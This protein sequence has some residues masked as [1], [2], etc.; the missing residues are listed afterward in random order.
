MESLTWDA[1][2]VDHHTSAPF[3]LA[4]EVRS[5]IFRPRSPVFAPANRAVTPFGLAHRR[6]SCAHLPIIASGLIDRPI[7]VPGGMDWLAFNDL[8]SSAR[9][10]EPG[11][12]S[13]VAALSIPLA[14]V[15][16]VELGQWQ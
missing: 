15:G 4:T 10:R 1:T 14:V 11:D 9:R 6:T 12:A 8:H 5:P 16:C 2:S 3:G 13:V 7:P